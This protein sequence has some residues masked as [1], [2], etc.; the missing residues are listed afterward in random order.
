MPAFGYLDAGAKAY[1]HDHRLLSSRT[2]R[3]RRTSLV[4]AG[5]QEARPA[6]GARPWHFP[7]GAQLVIGFEFCE[8][9]GFYSMV[10]LLALFLS[11][12]RAAGGFG[13]EDKPALTL[14][15]IFSG[16]M[17]ALPVVGG[18]IADRLLGHRQALTVGGTFM[19]GAYLLLT[20]SSS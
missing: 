2:L 9:V 16:L 19:F 6:A 11:A 4:A 10:S 18:W 3:A 13:W 5:L 8:R 7:R 15:G 17:Y 20:R 12:S 1:S 14:L